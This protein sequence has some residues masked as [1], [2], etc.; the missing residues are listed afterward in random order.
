MLLLHSTSQHF[1]LSSEC[2]QPQLVRSLI[3][4]N[5]TAVMDV[6]RSSITEDSYMSRIIDLVLFVQGQVVRL[7]T[8]TPARLLSGT[9]GDQ[10]SINMP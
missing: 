6:D 8:E 9:L 1:L 4:D 3:P 2:F 5:D 10:T 7:G